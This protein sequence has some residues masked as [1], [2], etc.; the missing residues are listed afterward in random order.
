MKLL[1]PGDLIE[2]PPTKYTLLELE[3][4]LMSLLFSQKGFVVEKIMKMTHFEL[5]I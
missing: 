3:I 2:T 5:V 1:S 4:N